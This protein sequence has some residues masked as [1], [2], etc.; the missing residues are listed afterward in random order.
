MSEHLC[1]QFELI[2]YQISKSLVAVTAQ[3]SQR[4][5]AQ[6]VP[7]PANLPSNTTANDRAS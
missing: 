6:P 1:I 2:K 3:R 5:A 4:P 7:S